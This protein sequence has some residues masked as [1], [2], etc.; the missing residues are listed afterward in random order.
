LAKT[1]QGDLIVKGL[2]FAIVVSRFNDFITDRLSSG[3]L[4]VFLRHGVSDKDIDIIKVPGSFELLLA[5]KRAAETK[6]YDALVAI[7]TIIKGQ[8]PH[9]DYL[10][11]VVTSNMSKISLDCNVPVCSGVV[12]TENVE[13]AIERAGSK[14]GNRGGEA[15]LSAIEMANLFKSFPK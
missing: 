5:L 6:R 3:A 11:S 15:A 14:V 9:Y 10:S 7:G 1:I 13:Q 4:D 12:I 2:K 8:T